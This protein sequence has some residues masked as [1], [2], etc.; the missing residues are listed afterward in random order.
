MFHTI[1]LFLVIKVQDL[2]HYK[3]KAK[4]VKKNYEQNRLCLFLQMTQKIHTSTDCISNRTN[5]PV[6]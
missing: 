6:A 5:M 1:S 2:A 4:P 3:K